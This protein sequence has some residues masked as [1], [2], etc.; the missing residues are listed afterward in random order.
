MKIQKAL[1]VPGYSS[2]YFDD[3]KAIK[4]GAGQDGLVYVG[5]PV[6]PGFEQ[7]RQAGECVSVLLLAPSKPVVKAWIVDSQ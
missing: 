1:F 4:Q 6:T 7:I 3:Q 5:Q 2:F